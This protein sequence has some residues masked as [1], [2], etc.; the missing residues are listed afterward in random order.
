MTLGVVEFAAATSR[1]RMNEDSHLARPPL[2]HRRRHG[3]GPRRRGSASA[4][5]V[6]SSSPVFPAGTIILLDSDVVFG[7]A[8]ES[9]VPLA[10]DGT[11]SGRHARVFRRDGSPYLEDLGSTNGTYVNGQ[12]LAA[13]RLLRPGTSSPSAPPSWSTRSPHDARRRRVRRR[14]AH[15]DDAPDER[16]FPS[17]AAAPVRDRRRHGRGPRRRG[18]LRARRLHVRGARR[19]D[20]PAG[21]A[22]PHHHRRGQHA[23]P[24]DVGARRRHGRHGDDDHGRAGGRTQRCRSG[25][26]ATP[27]PTCGAV[28]CCSRCPTTTRW[29]AS[30]CAAARSRP[31]RPSATRRRTSSPAP[32]APS[33]HWRSTRGRSRRRR[34]TS[35]C[36]PPT[37]SAT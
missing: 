30:W 29:S 14:H 23:H 24:R 18:R 20:G 4:L 17:G 37:A 10:A 22:A 12:P 5:A 11:V 3:R 2:L 16:G 36:S 13:E 8:A 34:A 25:T 21:G 32:S 19:H 26:S 7:R 1:R 6:S 9:D 15:G 27:A 31:R 33:R 35:S 28:A